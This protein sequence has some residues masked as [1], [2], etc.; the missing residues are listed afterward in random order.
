LQDK[1]VTTALLLVGLVVIV[2]GLYV[3]AEQV[4][5]YPIT[6]TSTTLDGTGCFFR[7][8]NDSLPGSTVGIC[9]PGMPQ[10]SIVSWHGSVT[11]LRYPNGTLV[12]CPS[13]RNSSATFKTGCIEATEIP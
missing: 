7:P 9:W 6:T 1:F 12:E 4:T 2:I 3:S 5:L 11:A 8:A 13:L 10:G